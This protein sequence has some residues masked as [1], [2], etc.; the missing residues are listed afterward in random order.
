MH[1]SFFLC[2]SASLLLSLGSSIR[3]DTSTPA[4]P[5]L[6]PKGDSFVIT[7]SSA[8]VW[9]ISCSSASTPLVT[10]DPMLLRGFDATHYNVLTLTPDGAPQ[11]TRIALPKGHFFRGNSMHDKEVG[12]VT[13]SATTFA[14]LTKL[15]KI[16]FNDIPVVGPTKA[17]TVAPTIDSINLDSTKI[18]AFDIA[19]PTK[20]DF[21][22]TRL[23]MTSATIKDLPSVFF[24]APMLKTANFYNVEFGMQRMSQRRLE[25]MQQLCKNH[26]VSIGR[27]ESYKT[28]CD[29]KMVTI[30]CSGS[31][32]LVCVVPSLD[33]DKQ[34]AMDKYTPKPTSQ[35]SPSQSKQI[36]GI[37]DL[38]RGAKNDADARHV[39]AVIVTAIASMVLTLNAL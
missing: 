8:T 23:S 9:T 29:G 14:G 36:N 1:Q 30:E 4:P 32:Y 20:G 33:G 13:F 21:N 22:L 10:F 16:Y 19:V 35:P 28:D 12:P 38:L 24:N 6:C 31:A 11:P 5:P 15:D 7:S 39:G 27:I 34:V 2:A 3:V 18:Q 26:T 17:W 25:R 37:E